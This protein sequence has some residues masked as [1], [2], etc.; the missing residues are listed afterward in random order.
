MTRQNE[1]VM[2]HSHIFTP[3][4]EIRAKKKLPTKCEN[5]I[6]MPYDVHCLKRRPGVCVCQKH[7]RFAGQPCSIDLKLGNTPYRPLLGTPEIDCFMCRSACEF[8]TSLCVE[9]L[10][11]ISVF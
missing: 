8:L 10:G 4:I 11:W 1:N 3:L 5:K 6:K 2:A 7:V 9:V